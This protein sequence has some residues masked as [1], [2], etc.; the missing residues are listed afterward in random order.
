MDKEKDIISRRQFFKRS[1][2]AILPAV[3]MVVLPSALT[4]CEYDPMDYP[5]LGGGSGSGSSNGCS[6]CKGAGCKN[7][8]VSTCYSTCT[9]TCK[10]NCGGKCSVGCSSL[11]KSS[12]VGKNKL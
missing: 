1:A 10:G 12:C 9:G 2:S 4:S 3:A 5:E 11:C 8:C 7:G 6:S